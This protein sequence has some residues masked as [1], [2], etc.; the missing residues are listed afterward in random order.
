MKNTSTPKKV[1]KIHLL[2]MSE[3]GEQTM[4]VFFERNL[5]DSCK[6]TASAHEAHAV[7]VDAEGYHAEEALEQHLL[8]YPKQQL[9]VLTM[10]PEQYAQGNRIIVRKPLD[11][12]AFAE[13]LRDLQTQLLTPAAPAACQ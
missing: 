2:G 7:L 13:T 5:S 3:R 10:T 4:R 1:L 9:I 11:T 12:T 6:I 8:Q